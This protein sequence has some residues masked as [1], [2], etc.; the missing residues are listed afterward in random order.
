MIQMDRGAQDY[1]KDKSSDSDDTTST[2]I[3]RHFGTE[4]QM[5]AQ[6]PVHQFTDDK[7]GDRQNVFTSWT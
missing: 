3:S 2:C 7:T 1:S 4:I 5:S 6:I